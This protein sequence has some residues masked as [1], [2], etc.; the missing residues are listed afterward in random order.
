[1]TAPFEDQKDGEEFEAAERDKTAFF[2][3]EEGVEKA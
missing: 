3:E 1:M 2:S